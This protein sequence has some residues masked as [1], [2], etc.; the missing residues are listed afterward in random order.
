MQYEHSEPVAP[1]GGL[2]PVKFLIAGGFGVGKT[3]HGRERSPRSS[4]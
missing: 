2:Q 1:Q 4:R 3:T